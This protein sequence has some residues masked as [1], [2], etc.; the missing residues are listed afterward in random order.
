MSKQMDEPILNPENFRFTTFPIKYPTIWELYQ[1][2]LAAF[3]K[4][5]EI[6]FSRDYDDFQTLNADEQH[7]VKMVLSFFAASDGIVNFNIS[8]RF[9]KDVKIL[10]AIYC[11]NFQSMMENIHAETYSLMLDNII[12][13]KAEKDRMFNAIK[14]IPSVKMM[15]NWAFKWIESSKSFHYR[16]IAFAAIE[17]IFFSGA[18]CCIFWLKRYRGNGKQFMNGLVS[19]NQLIARDESSHQLFGCELYK[20]LVNKLSFS[21]VREIIEDAVKVS[22][23]FIIESLPCRLIGMNSD[24]MSDYIEYVG[25]TLL[26]NLGYNKVWNKKNPFPFM[27]TI[28]MQSK[29]NFFEQRVMDYQSAHV[30]NTNKNIEISDDF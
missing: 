13:D 7:F 20:L 9:I 18:F 21:E 28:G 25:D 14:E 5:Q 17:G 10:E 2:Q 30:F 16:V 24:M 6:D 3:W 8:E 27:E 4:A 11:Y 12:R 26:V 1:R 19:S 15:A 22:K 29:T 23:N